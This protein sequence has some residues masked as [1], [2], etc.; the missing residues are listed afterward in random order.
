MKVCLCA[1]LRSWVEKCV[2]KRSAVPE[3]PDVGLVL[4]YAKL[5]DGRTVGL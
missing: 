5:A 1:P 4:R 2:W 3:T